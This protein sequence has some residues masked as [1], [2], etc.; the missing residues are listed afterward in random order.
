[1]GIGF[2]LASICLAVT[3]AAGSL[4]TPPDPADWGDFSPERPGVAVPAP[5]PTPTPTPAPTPP[6]PPT[7]GTGMEDVQASDWFYRYIRTGV[8]HGFLQ[9]NNNRFEPR[10]AI[11]RAEFVTMMGRMHSALGGVVRHDWGP[12]GVPTLPYTDIDRTAFYIPYLVWATELEIVQGD[13]EGRFR[14]NAPMTRQELATI[15]VRYIEAYD[16]ENHLRDQ[17]YDL[18]Q[19]YD[20]ELIAPWARAA[21]HL[22][23]NYNLMHG[24]RGLRDE[25]G[26]YFFRP[27][28]EALR[29]E[30]GVILVRLFAAVFDG[31]VAV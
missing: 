26:V 2:R 5:S 15:L 11:T 6:T 24:S 19:Y 20:W 17:F 22:L 18:G 7:P 21:A 3:L 31:R 12:G 13:A 28:D 9:G 1:M 30:A 8:R 10:R 29:L 4:L 25:P 27:E 16:V 23:R 14:P